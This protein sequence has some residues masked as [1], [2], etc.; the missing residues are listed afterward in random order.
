VRSDRIHPVTIEEALQLVPL[1]RLEDMRELEGA[2][3]NPLFA[4]P[5]SVSISDKAIKFLTS[6]GEIAGIAGVR[7]DDN[8]HGI[9]WMLCTKAVSKMPVSFVRGAKDWLLTLSNYKLLYNTADPRNILHLKLLKMLGFKKICYVP[10]GPK[11]LT[12]VEFAKIMPC[13]IQ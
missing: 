5:F 7:S 2:G 3:M 13:V 10:T 1:L 9:V 11:A 12:Y 6:E 4:L 8:G